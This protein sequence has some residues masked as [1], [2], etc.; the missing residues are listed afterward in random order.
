MKDT[1]KEL[2]DTSGWRL[3]LYVLLG[4]WAVSAVGSAVGNA[5]H[6]P[7]PVSI[8]LGNDKPTPGGGP[9]PNP[10]PNPPNAAA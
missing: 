8:S 5:I 7:Q 2:N 6:G 4:G 10:N 3:F 1:L 9:N